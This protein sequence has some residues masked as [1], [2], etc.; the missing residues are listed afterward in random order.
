MERKNR[1]ILSIGMLLIYVYAPLVVHGTEIRSVET[2]GTIGF[3]GI[4]EI[5]GT[6]DPAPEGAIKPDLPK[7]IAQHPSRVNHSIARLL[8]KTNESQ[9]HIWSTF[10]LLLVIIVLG[11][12]FWRHKKKKIKESRI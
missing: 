12:W 9:K 4:Y 10:G 6:P 7:E 1:C 5:P 3:T 8:P 11:F 2:E